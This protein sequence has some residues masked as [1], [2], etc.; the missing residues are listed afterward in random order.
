MFAIKK[1]ERWFALLALLIF[2]ALNSIIVMRYFDSGASAFDATF[3]SDFHIAGF[4]PYIWRELTDGKPYYDALRHPLIWIFLYPLFLLN[5]LLMWL[6]G[7]NCAVLIS[8]VLNTLLATYSA[9]FLSRICYRITERKSEAYLLTAFFFSFAYVMLATIVPDHFNISLFLLLLTLVSVKPSRWLFLVTSGVTLTNGVKVGLAYLF[10][11]GKKIFRPK[12]FI[13]TFVL[14]LILC[15][16]V[17]RYCQVAYIEPAQKA[18]IEEEARKTERLAQKSPE[19]L[20]RRNELRERFHRTHVGEPLSDNVPLLKWTDVT[21]PRCQT[22]VENLFGEGF[23]LHD[24]YTLKDVLVNRPVFVDSYN[25]WGNYVVEAVIILLFCV[26]AFYGRRSSLLLLP[27]SWFAFDMLMHMGLGFG[28]NEVYIMTA[29]WAFVI[30]VAVAF[31]LRGLRPVPRR[32][33]SLSVGAIAL[34]LWGYNLCVLVDYL[35][36]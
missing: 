28:I 1:D 7:A 22:F 11:S 34:Y 35:Y 26:G 9:I 2:A 21:T 31:L 33:A 19:K 29:H 25:V 24:N 23:M 27:L 30:P 32:I 10:N 6:T 20:K 3:I 12:F 14:P 17:A 15:F 5:M 13:V 18:H 4:D 8:A 16:G 36:L